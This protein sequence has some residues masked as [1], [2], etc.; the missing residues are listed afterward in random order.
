M[1]LAKL[2][3]AWCVGWS[4]LTQI[5]PITD[6]ANGDFCVVIGFHGDFLQAA[7]NAKEANN[8]V[9]I[10]YSIPAEG[11]TL[12]FDMVGIPKGAPHEKNGYAQECPNPGE[13][14]RP[15]AGWLF[16]LPLSGLM[17]CGCKRREMQR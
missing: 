9:E 5:L 10:A 14:S 4:T 13:C 3:T 12:W 11:S 1:A 17:V 6:L 16:A 7:S 8:G 2:P 15:A